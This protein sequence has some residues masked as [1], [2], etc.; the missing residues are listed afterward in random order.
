MRN[1]TELSLK[2]KNIVWY[3]IVAAFIGGIFSYFQL[4]RMEDP[5][6]VIREMIVAAYWSGATADEMQEQVTDKLEKKLQDIPNLDSLTSET[7]PGETIIY[8]E[9]DEEPST[10]QIRPTWR[11]VRN[12]CNDIKDELPEGVMGPF[13]NDTYDEVFG[14]IYALTGDGF[15]YEELRKNAEEI[16][17]LMLGIDDVKKIELVGEQSEIVYVEI[18]QSKLSELG[19]SPQVISETLAAQNSMT[20]AGMVDTSSDNVYLRVTGIFDDVD[21][22][23][24][25]PINADGKIFRLADIAKVERRFIDPPEPK[26]FF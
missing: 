25:L 21:E 2:N 3:F 22:I 5:K 6:F 18:E 14:S 15:S 8:V 10:E 23:K 1:L 19:I 17:R 12:Y 11:D 7:R 26:M 13:F 24:N 4:G 16:R 20:P 9:L